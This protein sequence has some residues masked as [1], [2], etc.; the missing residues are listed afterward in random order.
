MG[1]S[2]AKALE[3][4]WVS[5]LAG[6]LSVCL[7]VSHLP[8]IKQRKAL[9]EGCLFNKRPWSIETNAS[10]RQREKRVQLPPANALPSS[11][12]PECRFSTFQ[13]LLGLF[14]NALRFLIG[15]IQDGSR[16]QVEP[17]VR[18]VLYM[19]KCLLSV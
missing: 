18:I 9:P 15:I 2:L 3:S 7:T 16:W 11:W 5:A 1:R 14:Q 6:Y 17:R 12:A 4:T 8:P 13:Q 19:N 10:A